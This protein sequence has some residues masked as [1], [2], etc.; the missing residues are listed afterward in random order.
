MNAMCVHVC[1]VCMYICHVCI[2][3]V[4][5][6]VYVCPCV[7]LSLTNAMLGVSKSRPEPW[8]TAAIAAHVSHAPTEDVLPLVDMVCVCV[9]PHVCI[10][11]KCCVCACA[12]VCVCVCVAPCVART[13]RGCIAACGHDVCVLMC[14]VCVCV[15]WV[16]V[17]C[18]CV[19]V[20]VHSGAQS[21]SPL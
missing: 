6:R 9:L 18:E 16:V 13:S 2:Y 7:L 20:A 1:S 8:V 4:C 17:L 15:N 3:V 10:R 11:W 14:V 5:A 12:Y 19:C 21:I